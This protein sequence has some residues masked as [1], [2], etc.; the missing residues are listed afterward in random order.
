MMRKLGIL[1]ALC[2]GMF[3]AS[4]ASAQLLSH[5]VWTA[6]PANGLVS[7]GTGV[8]M[9]AH[10]TG[11]LP[12]GA[13]MMIFDGTSI[14]ADGAL[15]TA[16]PGCF[17]IQATISPN[18]TSTGWMANDPSPVVITNGLVVVA[19]SSADCFHLTKI[20]NLYISAT[21]VQ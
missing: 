15:A 20:S 17:T 14:P 8:L 1:V 16:P 18:I 13:M 21:V 4:P 6:T 9:G 11:A 12:A 2:A 10:I 19:S 3:C 7:V 5:Q